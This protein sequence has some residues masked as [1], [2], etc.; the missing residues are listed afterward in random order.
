MVEL[1]E[2]YGARIY[3]LSKGLSHRYIR[4]VPKAGGGY[5]YFYHVGHGGGVA[6]TD[7]FVEGAAFQHEGGHFHITKTDGDRLTIRHD[8][9]G[10][11]KTVTKSGLRDMLSAHHGEAIKAHREKAHADLADARKAGASPK[12][13]ARL[14]ARAKAAG[15]KPEEKPKNEA[16]AK[17]SL[18]D[19]KTKVTRVS[20]S[21]WDVEIT[22]P[23]G[24]T[25]WERVGGERPIKDEA[26][27]RKVALE[28][29][30]AL[31]GSAQEACKE[32]ADAQ[33]ELSKADAERQ[34][35]RM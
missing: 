21:K 7:H 15:P 6:N 19:Y 25:K 13:I 14:E 32:S 3:A 5:R 28:Q 2:S 8:E 9:T 23:S 29:C 27:A 34:R 35:G 17:P 33:Y 16:K 4:R 18:S 22:T 20:A 31:S 11:T 24:Q 12:Q 30:E 26:E 1:P 10:E